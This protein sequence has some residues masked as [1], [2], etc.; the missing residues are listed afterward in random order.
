MHT[1]QRCKSDGLTYGEFMRRVD[2][3]LLRKCGLSH[4]DLSDC[5][6]RD[7]WDDDLLVEDAAECILDE[8]DYPSDED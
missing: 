7:M 8:N 4:L 2:L 5:C 1:A 3:V 6:T